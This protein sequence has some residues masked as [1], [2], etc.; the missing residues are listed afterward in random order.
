MKVYTYLLDHHYFSIFY[1]LHTAFLVPVSVKLDDLNIW[2]KEDLATTN[3]SRTSGFMYHTTG[4]SEIRLSM[5][6][7]FLVLCVLRA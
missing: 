7:P 2:N 4:V 5:E 6:V 1:V 3:L